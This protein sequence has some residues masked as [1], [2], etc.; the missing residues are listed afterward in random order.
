MIT[1]IKGGLNLTKVLGFALGAWLLWAIW[2]KVQGLVKAP[3]AGLQDKAV[4]RQVAQ[5]TGITKTDDADF[6]K[7]VAQQCYDAIWGGWGWAEDEAAFSA[8][9]NR[10]QT[11]AQ[12][13]ATSIYYKQL[14]P[15][16]GLKMDMNEYLSTS[17]INGIKMTVRSAITD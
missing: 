16:R 5:N 11:K 6:C 1:A 14:K 9:L 2:K 4:D 13:K 15:T 10:L 8:A 3:L 7:E 12:A 17:D